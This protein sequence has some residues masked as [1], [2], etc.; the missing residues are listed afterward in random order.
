M[1]RVYL[2]YLIN[3]CSNPV[4]SVLSLSSLFYRGEKRGNQRLSNLLKITQ[5][6]TGRSRIQA[7][8]LES[9][10]LTQW[11]IKGQGGVSHSPRVWTMWVGGCTAFRELK[12]NKETG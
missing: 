3:I 10:C 9:M 8:E 6:V 2:P 11:Y 12:Y 4:R 7:P 5:L 1:L